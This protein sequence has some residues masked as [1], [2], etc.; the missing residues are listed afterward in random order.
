MKLEEEECEACELHVN[1]LKETHSD[2]VQYVQDDGVPEEHA[3]FKR[4]KIDEKRVIEGCEECSEF[5]QY[6]EV[7]NESRRLYKVD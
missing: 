7:A 5:T 3:K 1:H 6:I 4:K 2:D